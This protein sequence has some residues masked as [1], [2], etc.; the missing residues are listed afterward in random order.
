MPKT[1]KIKSKKGFVIVNK[2]GL[3]SG[4]VFKTLEETSEYLY[5]YW[6]PICGPKYLEMDI[7]PKFAIISTLEYINLISGIIKPL[8]QLKK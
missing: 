6:L 1:L 2:Q 3:W 7:K 5:N 8:C 4:K